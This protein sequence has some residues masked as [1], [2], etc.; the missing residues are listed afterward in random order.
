VGLLVLVR[1]RWSE[2]GVEASA[3][4]EGEHST[5]ETSFG[6]MS[7]M[8]RMSKRS[9]MFKRGRMSKLTRILQARRRGIS[10]WY[11]SLFGLSVKCKGEYGVLVSDHEFRLMSF[12]SENIEDVLSPEFQQSVRKSTDK[13]KIEKLS[14]MC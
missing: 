1:R 10:L 3:E 6:R 8:S 13:L 9:R 5:P 4:W 7:L 12:I 11:F 14:L 2:C